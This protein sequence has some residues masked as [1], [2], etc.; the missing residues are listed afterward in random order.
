MKIRKHLRPAGLIA[1]GVFLG[2]GAQADTVIDFNFATAPGNNNPIYQNFGGYATNSSD[3]VTVTGF[4]TPNIGLTWVGTGDPATRWEFYNDGVWSAGQ[5]NHSIV[6]SANEIVFTPNNANARAVI[7][8]FNFHPYYVFAKY[9]EVFTY[10]VSVLS[11][12]NVLSGP[13]HTT[14]LSDGTKNHPVNVNYTGAPGQILKL[15]MARVASVLGAGEVEG[16]PGDI[17]ADDI[18]F[19]QLPTSEL[20]VGPQVVSV[21]PT[22]DQSGVAGANYSYFASITNGDTT[23]VASSIKLKFDGALVSPPPVISSTN[24][25]TNVFYSATTLLPPASTHFYTLT[26]SDNLGATYTNDTVF[27][28]A[29]Y[30]TLPPSYASPP[31]SGSHP[32]FTWRSVLARQ[33]ITNSLDSSIARAIAQLN[34]TLTD[35]DIGGLLTN[36]V[37]NGTNADGSFDIDGVINFNDNFRTV[38]Q[39]FLGDTLFPGLD[40]G[41]YN[42]FSCEGLLFLDL[43]A[44]YYRLGVNSDDGFQLNALPPKGVSGSPIVLGLF[45]N[46]RAASDTLCDFLVQT[47]GVYG[48]QLIYFESDGDANC[49]FFSVNLATGDL[50]LVNDLS[51]TNA[52]K[53]FRV[54]PP[55]ITSIVRSGS[56]V[57]ISWAYGNPPFQVQFKNNINGPWSNS[58][59]PTSNRTALVPIQPGAGFF[60]VVGSP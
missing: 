57:S 3:G 4:G 43:P 59:S 56:N 25:T 9:G 11:G 39:H 15:K 8:S 38:G 49:E 33:D 13:I 1:L 34:G 50:I 16:F 46:G 45:D 32:G 28:I 44:G 58:G 10:D 5:L 19:A 40:L 47:N 12:T 42:W 37:P 30:P 17:A 26:Y 21:S 35:P 41:P 14:Y 20:A 23:L 24:D 53:S 27:T 48:F 31:G 2:H 55:R 60:R 18:T 22:D 36:A 51:N 29:T 52:I 54:V 7:K 6:G